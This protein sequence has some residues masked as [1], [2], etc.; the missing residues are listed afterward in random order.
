HDSTV[1]LFRADRIFGKEHLQVAAEL[2]IRS[3]DQ[4][5]ARTKT[6]GMEIMLYA[7]AERQ[8]SG[9]ID[10]LGVQDDT[11]E[12]AIITVGRINPEEVLAE[13]NLQMADDVLDA[14]GKDYSIYKISQ[15]ELNYASAS[16]IILE[17]MALSEL[18]R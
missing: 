17:R 6:L 8:I 5:T 2:A 1:Q 16:E 15:E 13:L 4:G 9:A 18:N 12:I 11:T 3:W 14:E 10:K 7:A